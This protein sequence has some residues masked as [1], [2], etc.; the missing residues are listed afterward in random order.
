MQ[1][2]GLHAARAGESEEHMTCPKCSRTLEPLAYYDSG[3]ASAP[4]GHDYA[5]NV[6][7]CKECQIIARE[8]VWDNP[9]VVWITPLDRP[10]SRVGEN[11]TFTGGVFH[12]EVGFGVKR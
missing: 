3:V 8:S 11:P 2:Y 9:G 10:F 7:G 1:G 6:Y 4:N 12:R 5:C